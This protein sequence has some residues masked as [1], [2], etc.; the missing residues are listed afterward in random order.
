MDEMVAEEKPLDQTV[1]PA[2]KKEVSSRKAKLRQR[3]TAEEDDEEVDQQGQSGDDSLNQDKLSRPGV[4][5]EARPKPA[6][7]KKRRVAKTIVPGH[8]AA[9]DDD[10]ENDF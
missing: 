7:K 9:E 1:L 3:G 10:A 4:V 5:D 8:L 2:P 6:A